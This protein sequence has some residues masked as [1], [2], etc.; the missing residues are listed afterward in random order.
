MYRFTRVKL[1]DDNIE[2][3]YDGEKYKSLSSFMS[4]NDLTLQINYDGVKL[5]ESSKSSLWEVMAMIME[6]PPKLR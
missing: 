2:D 6:L 1:N 5:F 3:V 4:W